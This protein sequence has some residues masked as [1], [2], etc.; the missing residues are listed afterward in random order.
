[1]GGTTTVEKQQQQQSQSAPWAP[2]QPFLNN[3]LAN[4]DVLSHNA[5]PTAAETA[6]INQMAANA[7]N[8]PNLV[9]AATGLMGALNSG[10]IDRTGILGNAYSNYQ[11][12]LSPY[13][14]GQNLDPTK[15]PGM[16]SVLDTIRNDVSNNVNSQFAA[17][18]R[19]LSGINQQSLARGI[20]QGEAA[21]LLAQYNQNVQNQ[22]GAAGS[23]Y[24]AGAGTAAGLSGLDQ[25]ALSNRLQGLGVGASIPELANV[26]PNAALNAGSVWRNLPLGNLSNIQNLI[27]PIAQLGQQSSGSSSGTESTTAPMGPSILAGL[28][29]MGAIGSKFYQP[30]TSNGIFNTGFFGYK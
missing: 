19:D 1:M 11:S 10:G 8:A 5:A 20:A 21:P 6:A 9:P 3:L 12:Q 14:N 13:A 28:L 4:Y 29:G 7:Q 27:L 2:T 22:L 17:A 24:G 30:G 15:A 16:Q 18:G 23:L 25:T 26:G